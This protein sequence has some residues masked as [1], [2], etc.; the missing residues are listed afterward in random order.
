MTLVLPLVPKLGN[1]WILTF[2]ELKTF[3]RE[4]EVKKRQI[5]TEKE[6]R[7]VVLLMRQR[8]QRENWKKASTNY[9]QKALNKKKKSTLYLCVQQSKLLTGEV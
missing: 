2:H 1:T 6:E 4:R 3:S 9:T 7:I 5:Q 8:Q